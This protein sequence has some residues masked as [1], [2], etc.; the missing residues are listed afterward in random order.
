MAKTPPPRIVLTGGPAGGKTTAI[1]ICRREF[2]ER[3]AVVRESATLLYLGGFVRSS[4]AQKIK[5]NQTAIYQVQQSL[6]KNVQDLYPGIPLICDRGTLDGAAYWPGGAEGFFRELNT[7]REKE[8]ARY[9]AV[10][11][12]ETAAVGEKNLDRTNTTRTETLDEAIA[13][14]NRLQA[15]WSQHPKFQLISHE[16][17]FF[18]KMENALRT[19]EAVLKKG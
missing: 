10:L 11:F 3:I 13:I 15:I 7:T 9:A 1:E 18:K 17:S 5:A 4:E 6:E 19:I 16:K 2:A 14:N 8:Y 12:F